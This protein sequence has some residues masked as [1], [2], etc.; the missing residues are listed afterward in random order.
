M[1]LS[2][3]SYDRR[4][5]MEAAVDDL[6][7]RFDALEDP[8]ASTATT[9]A[10]AAPIVEPAFFVAA[11]D[12]SAESKAVAHFT[13]SG[14]GKDEVEIMLALTALPSSTPTGS[15]EIARG[16]VMLSEGTFGCDGRITVPEGAGLI[17]QGVGTIL[18]D[19]GGNGDFDI[20]I[21][22]RAE[23][24]HFALDDGV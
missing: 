23:V 16:V 4:S 11:S 15:S 18:Y 1:T 13:C 3:R 19:A 12:A 24:A 6:L 8:P 22:A 5:A 9:T 21:E 17:G 14:V 20:V 7:R 2:R 10:G